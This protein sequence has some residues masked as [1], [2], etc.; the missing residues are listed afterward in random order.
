[1]I[2]TDTERAKLLENGAARARGE[3]RDSQPVVKLYT[4][5]FRAI[6]LLTELD[7]VDGDTAYGLCDA[8][9]GWPELGR[10]SISYLESMRGPKGMPVARDPDFEPRR[11]LAEYFRLAQIARAVTE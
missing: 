11:T 3:P 8:G 10:I 1:M 7:P 2:L 6:W 4:P 9:I 5:D